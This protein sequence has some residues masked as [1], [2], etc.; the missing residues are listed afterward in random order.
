VSLMWNWL[1]VKLGLRTDWTNPDYAPPA[2]EDTRPHE[3]SP[4]EGVTC[5]GKCGAGKL[6]RVHNTE[7]LQGEV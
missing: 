2:F 7:V 3:F 6:H 5:C 4:F 1:L